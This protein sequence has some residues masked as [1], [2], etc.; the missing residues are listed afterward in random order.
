MALLGTTPIPVRPAPNTQ[1][2]TPATPPDVSIPATPVTT[3]DLTA[4]IVAT[5]FGGIF[6]LINL[7]LYL[8]LYGDFTTPAEQGLALSPWDLAAL[9]GQE[10]CGEKILTDPVW[11]LL[12]RLAGRTDQALP[13]QDFDPPEAWRMPVAWLKPF[14]EPGPWQKK[15]PREIP[16]WPGEAR[17][18]TA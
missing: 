7:A 1:S 16:R 12:A 18:L 10:F 8:N 9:V 15:P 5:E 2:E 11:P 3:A 14:P 13:G 17:L 4:H 6:F